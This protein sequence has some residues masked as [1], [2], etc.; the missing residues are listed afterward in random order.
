MIFVMCLLASTRFILIISDLSSAIIDTSRRATSDRTSS[1][2]PI[3]RGKN[4]ISNLLTLSTDPRCWDHNKHQTR[5]KQ[6]FIRLTSNSAVSC[7]P[8]FLF[9]SPIGFTLS[10]LLIALLPTTIAAC[11][12]VK[13]DSEKRATIRWRQSKMQRREEK[14]FRLVWESHT[15]LRDLNTYFMA[16]NYCVDIFSVKWA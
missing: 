14:I 6:H 10:H 13:V 12:G 15:C 7:L 3:V 8:F 1:L 11:V 2:S 4:S 9:S 5:S 16:A